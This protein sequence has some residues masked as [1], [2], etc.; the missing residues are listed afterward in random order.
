MVPEHRMLI[1]K[2][3]RAEGQGK[4]KTKKTMWEDIY[5]FTLNFNKLNCDLAS[6]E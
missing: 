4:D 2:D 6:P 1:A 3:G 5:T